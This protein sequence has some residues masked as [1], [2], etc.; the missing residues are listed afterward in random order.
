MPDWPAHLALFPVSP[1]QNGKQ[2]YLNIKKINLWKSLGPPI[3]RVGRTL[4]WSAFDLDLDFA[5]D[6]FAEDEQDSRSTVEE[7]R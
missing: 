1:S 7:R 2:G 5:K 3:A 6:D 4:L